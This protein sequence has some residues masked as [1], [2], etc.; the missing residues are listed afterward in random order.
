MKA[1]HVH[2]DA[3]S[4]SGVMGE[5]LDELGIDSVEHQVCLTSGSPVGSSVFPDP[6]QFDLIFV[7]GSRWSVYDA[8]VKH[9]V[10]PELELLRQAD[11][12]GVSVLGMCFGGQLLSLAHGGGVAPG[13]TAEVGWLSVQPVSPT[14]TGCGIPLLSIDSGPWM[15]WHFDCFE[16][17]PGA[18]LLADSSA[19]PQAFLL[20][21]NLAVQ[22]HPEVNRCV[23]EE[24]L[25]D[26]LDQLAEVGVDPESL[27]I[28]AE[29]R[30]AESRNRASQLLRNFLATRSAKNKNV[31]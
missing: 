13:H 27:L 6:T 3:N 8:A 23:L 11:A 17:P 29:R 4:S 2:H 5:L 22:F 26:D 15:Q 12:A 14:P 18:Q 19:G 20:R 24:W 10:A 31:F 16:V 30:S 21:N 7:Y 1:L 25:V 9:W 28:E